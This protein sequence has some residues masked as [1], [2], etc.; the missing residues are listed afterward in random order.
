[1]KI[2]LKRIGVFSGVKTLFVLGGV[3][4]FL[5]GL[6]EWMLLAMISGATGDLSS[7]LNGLD[8]TGLSDLIA[9]GIGALGLFLPLFSAFAGAVGGVVFG[10]ILIGCYNVISRVIGGV[11]VEWSEVETQAHASFA[12]SRSSSPGAATPLPSS[13]P[14]PTPPTTPPTSEPE[15]RPP[16]MYE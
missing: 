14:S 5:I 10:T 7:G 8:Q 4:G 2:E 16:A 11:E 3:A 15:R 6:M 9:G 12:P 13:M 1:M